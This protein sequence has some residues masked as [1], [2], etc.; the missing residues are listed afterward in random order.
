MRQYPKQ[1]GYTLGQLVAT[2][3]II[4]AAAFFVGVALVSFTVFSGDHRK[5]PQSSCASNIKQIQLGVLQ[6]IQD[7]DEKF[8]PAARP[9]K[10]EKGILSGWAIT[11]DT[12]G[13]AAV[14]VSAKGTT[15]TQKLFAKGPLDSYTK[16][17][18]IFRCP[19]VPKNAG[20][21]SYMVNDLAAGKAQKVFSAVASTILVCEGEDF[22]G[23]V[24][25]AYDPT[26]PPAPATFGPTGKVILG[27]TLQTAPIR[28]NGGANYGFADGHVRW[29]KPEGIY[30]PSRFDWAAS[31]K[32]ARPNGNGP[33][34]VPGGD[35][36]GFY[37]T[38]H[39]N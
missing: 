15:T 24:G 1:N 27:A 11:H 14:S 31:H 25:H 6:Y 32:D 19:S 7:Y 20:P 35:M 5:S 8:P 17:E 23:N 36:H 26:L 18:F 2:L 28:H 38:F 22:A 29:S 9:L 33:T 16:N 34:P 10:N 4:T 37:G 3:M 12:D 13:K 21:L 30:F 39:L